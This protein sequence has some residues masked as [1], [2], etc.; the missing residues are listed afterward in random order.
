MTVSVPSPAA[1]MRARGANMN[2]RYLAMIAIGAT[3]L[4]A[5]GAPAAEHGE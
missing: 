4:R 3:G 5:A 2:K 1:R